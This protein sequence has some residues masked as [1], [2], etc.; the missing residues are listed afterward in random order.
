MEGLVVCTII[1]IGWD[2]TI[3]IL[4][5]NCITGNGGFGGVG[6]VGGKGPG[7]YIYNLWA[8]NQI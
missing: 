3:V 4:T 1:M 2:K 6:G 5:L 8:N 7:I